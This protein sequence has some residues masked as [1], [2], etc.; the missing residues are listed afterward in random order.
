MYFSISFSLLLAFIISYFLFNILIRNNI[1]FNL[2]AQPNDNTITH[3]TPIPLIGGLG[4]FLGI[5]L[6]T[7]IFIDCGFPL[8][9]YLAGLFPIAILGIYKDRFQSPL[10]PLIQLLVQTISSLVLYFHWAEINH[11]EFHWISLGIFIIICCIIMNAYNFIDVMDGLAGSYVL[12]VLIIL[13]IGS[14]IHGNIQHIYIVFSFIGAIIA[15]L[16]FNWRPAKIFMGDL[17][18]FGLV[19]SVLFILILERP[20]ESV[21]T[22]LAYIF[23]FFLLILEFTFTIF[24]RVAKRAS[25]LIGDGVHIS[26]ILLKKG[27]KSE[28]IVICAIIITLIT[29]ILAL[30][31][32]KSI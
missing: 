11:I 2:I 16:K 12:I 5:V 27:V 3:V 19:Y 1:T 10:S 17:G 18:S 29:N 25:P 31:Y 22:P 26:T 9:T 24:K 32:I 21:S 23:I 7:L 28:V 30:I 4:I 6:P 15:F 13:G 20:M 14:I 8:K